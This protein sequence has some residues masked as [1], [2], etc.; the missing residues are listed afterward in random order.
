MAILRI[1][2]KRVEND[3]L[4]DGLVQVDLAIVRSESNRRGL[5]SATPNSLRGGR[6]PTGTLRNLANQFHTDTLRQIFA[7]SIRLR[8]TKHT[9]VV[10]RA[11]FFRILLG[12][13][14]SLRCI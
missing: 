6:R 5:S 12:N 1:V 3:L 7:Q 13:S 8:P 11:I 14:G 2:L 4:S 10:L 9:R